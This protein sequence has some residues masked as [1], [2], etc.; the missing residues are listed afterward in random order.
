MVISTPNGKK[1]RVFSVAGRVT[2][3]KTTFLSE[4]EV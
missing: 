3:V 1:V 2:V 4:L